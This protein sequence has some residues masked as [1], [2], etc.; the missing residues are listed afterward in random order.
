M[1]VCA[2]MTRQYYLLKAHTCMV[3]K[4]WHFKEWGLFFIDRIS[5]IFT[6]LYYLFI[7]LFFFFFLAD[8]ILNYFSHFP[9]KQDLPFEMSNPVLETI[10][11]KGFLGKNK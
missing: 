4:K 2:Y 8:D 3:L 6:L 1:R 11:M 10:C 5:F 7:F 9:Q